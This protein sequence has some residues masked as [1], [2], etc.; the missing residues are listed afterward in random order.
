MRADAHPEAKVVGWQ[1]ID[2]NGVRVCVCVCVCV[3]VSM[4]ALLRS[5]VEFSEWISHPRS[6]WWSCRHSWI[7]HFGPVYFTTLHYFERN[8]LILQPF[9]SFWLYLD[10]NPPFV[11]TK[12]T[13]CLSLPRLWAERFWEIIELRLFRPKLPLRS[14]KLL[15]PFRPG[16]CVEL[17]WCM[18]WYY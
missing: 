9:F 2:N 8:M 11:Y 17:N 16:L 3:C 14:Y 1:G 5:R 12:G 15:V 18:N 4:H 13:T 10:S 7:S 6:K